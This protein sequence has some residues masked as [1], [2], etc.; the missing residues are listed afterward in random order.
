MTEERD[1]F[2]QQKASNFCGFAARGDYLL[3]VFLFNL[4]LGLGLRKHPC[5]IFT[6]LRRGEVQGG[7]AVVAVCLLCC[8]RN[9]RNDIWSYFLTPSPRR[10]EG[11]CNF[12]SNVENVGSKSTAGVEARSTV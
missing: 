2:P 4:N 3:A 10:V 6:N 1:S 12:L 11:R 9:R 8:N 7:E 5:D